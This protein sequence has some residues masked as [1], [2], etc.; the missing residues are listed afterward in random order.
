MT[1][2][3]LWACA[4][5]WQWIDEKEFPVRVR[6]PSKDKAGQHQYKK[7]HLS[8]EGNEQDESA[9]SL[10]TNEYNENVPTPNQQM[11]IIESS[12]SPLDLDLSKLPDE[13]E[14][15][16]SPDRIS[17]SLED[18]NAMNEEVN[19]AIYDG[20]SS[21]SS[22]ELKDYPEGIASR[23]RKRPVNSEPTSENTTETGSSTDREGA[24]EGKFDDIAALLEREFEADR[25]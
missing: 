22:D 16:F 25:V 19:S 7:Q 12:V 9:P 20:S 18:I 17:F 23:K 11:D 2:E 10:D 1:P 24:A 5:S 13:S 4:E 14:H 6:R 8:T 15:T 21:S 3:W